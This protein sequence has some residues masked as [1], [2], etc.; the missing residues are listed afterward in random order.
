MDE[1]IKELVKSLVCQLDDIE[2][3][4]DFDALRLQS[5][6]E[7]GAEAANLQEQINA[8]KER[9]LDVNRDFPAGL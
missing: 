3:E 7:I 5:S 2:K 9:L 6:Q 1:L 4:V 8:L